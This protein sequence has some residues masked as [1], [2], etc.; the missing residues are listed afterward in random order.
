MADD[1]WEHGVVGTYTNRKCR[2]E[3]CRAAN[4]AYQAQRKAQRR[5]QLAAN[6]DLAPH[7]IATT[8]SNWGCRC[9]RCTAAWRTA[10]ADRAQRRGGVD[11]EVER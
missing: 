5:E 3:A 1:D 7:G 10:C 6:P 4:S 8:Y 9:A 2:C 11:A